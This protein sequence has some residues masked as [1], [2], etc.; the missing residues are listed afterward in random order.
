MS[1]SDRGNPIQAAVVV[2]L[3]VGGGWYFLQ[4]YEIDGLDEVSINPKDDPGGV[5]IHHV[6]PGANDSGYD[7]GIARWGRVSNETE[8]PFTLTRSVRRTQ[9]GRLC[10]TDS[11]K[12]PPT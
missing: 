4:H 2:L 3:L 1:E 9:R 7:T 5:D 8:N 12:F 11:A 10:Q 6:S